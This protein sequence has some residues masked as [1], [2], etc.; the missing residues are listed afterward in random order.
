MLQQ[1]EAWFKLFKLGHPLI[2]VCLFFGPDEMNEE[3]LFPFFLS[4]HCG[5]V[6]PN[7]AV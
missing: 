7:V 2:L 4:L 3:F 5:V 6:C 1:R